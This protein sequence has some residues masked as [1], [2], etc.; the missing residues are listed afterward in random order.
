MI[1]YNNIIALWGHGFA[2]FWN[3]RLHLL[4]DWSTKTWPSRSFRVAATVGFPK[5]LQRLVAR[6]TRQAN[7]SHPR[8]VPSHLTAQKPDSRIEETPERHKQHHDRYCSSTM[9]D[10]VPL[11]HTYGVYWSH[12]NLV[13]HF[14]VK[15]IVLV[16]VSEGHGL[17]RLW[18]P[19]LHYYFW[20]KYIKNDHHQRHHH[21]H[22]H[23]K[24]IS[25]QLGRCGWYQSL[26][27]RAYCCTCCT[28]PFYT[29]NNVKT[30]HHQDSSVVHV[31]MKG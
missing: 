1:L 13:K 16:R 4:L 30:D 22:D 23:Q 6:G 18:N 25:P 8:D 5:K 12:V 11:L 26:Y 31:F 20:S 15:T 3:P 17:A 29:S 24:N 28:I 7:G 10:I 9:I 27:L 2:S 21:R 19:T 14:V